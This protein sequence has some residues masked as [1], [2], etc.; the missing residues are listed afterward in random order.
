MFGRTLASV[1]LQHPELA[2]E[3]LEDDVQRLGLRGVS[4]G[5][6]VNGED[7]SLPK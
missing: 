1:A 4:I 2:A 6:H 7:L 3:Q 5:G